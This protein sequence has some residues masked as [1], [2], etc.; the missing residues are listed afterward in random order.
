MTFSN[1]DPDQK[2]CLSN[3]IIALHC[4]GSSGHQWRA[5]KEGVTNKALVVAPELAGPEIAAR[6][7][8]A[9]QF[10][11]ADE[12]KP[13]VAYLNTLP[14]Q[15]HLVGH[16]YGGALAL[17][18]AQHHPHLVKSLNVYEPTAFWMIKHAEPKLF[19]EIANLNSALKSAIASGHHN[20]AAEVFTDFWGGLGAWQML[21]GNRKGALINWIP[22][23]TFDFDAL[24]YAPIKPLNQ[25]CPT[26]AYVGEFTRTQ[27]HE[28]CERLANLP[29]TKPIR[30]KGA[31]HLGPCVFK[32]KFASMVLNNIQSLEQIERQGLVS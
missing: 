11:L 29:N 26:A 19:D 12:A 27:T 21:S 23:I 6:F 15:V 25:S 2:I 28:I 22:K 24:L 10:T 14:T 32:H 31:D 30:M 8:N 5:L 17:H 1:S 4:S 18:I 3:P 16:S 7:D 9:R 13:I 20:Y